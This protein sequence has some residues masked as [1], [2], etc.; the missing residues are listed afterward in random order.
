[1]ATDVSTSDMA[2][3]PEQRTGVDEPVGRLL[4]AMLAVA[5]NL[6]LPAVLRRIVE[7][8]CTLA[9]ARYGA[10]GVLGEDEPLAEFVAVGVDDS[11]VRA[12]G[13]TPE[14]KGILGLLILDPRPL[15]LADLTR[16]P[17]AAGFPAG[18]PAMRSFL[19]V[20]IRV[21]DEVFGN[22]YLTEKAGGGEFTDEDEHL[23]VSLAAAAGVAIENVTLHEKLQAVV[24]LE[25]RE[26]IA[27]D[28]HDKVIQRLF[29]TGMALQATERLVVKP[30]VGLRIQQAVDELD[31]TIREIR[32]TIFALQTPVRNS[33]RREVLARTTE[34]GEIL[35]FEPTVR[36]EGPVDSVV[37]E[38]VGGELLTVLQEALSNAVRHARARRIDVT[39]AVGAD[40]LLR[41]ADD[42]VGFEPPQVVRGHGLRNMRLRAEALGGGFDVEARREGGT[43]AEWHVPLG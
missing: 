7:S 25:D 38:A 39:L 14:G 13:H 22:L 16:H 41:V 24:L 18:H 6:S 12:I 29:A 27:R 36:F 26:R 42:G 31:E 28:L 3:R 10:L 32:A 4:D 11:T 15:R 37:P 34:A 43:V 8:A 23:V 40:V 5:G 17:D 35:G 21:R 1:M 33:L 30:D 20:P 2:D 9:G 19:G